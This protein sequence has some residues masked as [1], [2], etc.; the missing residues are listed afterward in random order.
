M[1]RGPAQVR[2]AVSPID[3]GAQRGARRPA[4]RTTWIIIALLGVL[5][6]GT[7]AGSETSGDGE[8]DSILGLDREDFE[9]DDEEWSS[10]DDPDEEGAAGSNPL[11]SVSK[12]DL[13]WEFLKD[14]GSDINNFSLLG[15][16][17]L[18]PRLKL[19]Y[20]IHYGLTNRTGRQENDWDSLVIKPIL[21]P[22]DFDLSDRFGVRIATGF[23]W[24]IDF[25]N[26]DKGIGAGSDIAGPLLGTAIMDRELNTTYI[27][28]VQHFESYESGDVSQTAFRFIALQ[29]LPGSAWFKLDAKLISD[30]ENH[31][32]PVISEFELGK[33]VWKN[34]GVYAKVLT[35]IGGE[36]T[37]D[38]G[39]A[40]AVR[41]SF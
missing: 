33:V 12:V 4:R 8:E 21:F 5:G 7:P 9:I 30:W 10:D 1:K 22:K 20:E 18:H 17:M 11:A 36:R 19:N 40:A 16:T 25:G 31:E 28:L 26:D 38:W 3:A 24:L 23:E 27:P 14:A 15:A 32:L 39:T 2:G 29:P 41:V 34:I 6:A 37:F 35:G 13:E